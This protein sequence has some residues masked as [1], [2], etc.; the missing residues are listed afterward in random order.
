MMIYSFSFSNSFSLL[1]LIFLFLLTA[2]TSDGFSH[3][4]YL[5]FFLFF[6]NS[7]FNL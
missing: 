6:L 5:F 2:P 3:N 4:S 7:D 1:F